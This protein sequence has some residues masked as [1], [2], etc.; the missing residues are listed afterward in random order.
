MTCCPIEI[1][2]S[3]SSCFASEWTNGT[4]GADTR[5]MGPG[6]VFDHLEGFLTSS[7]DDPMRGE[8]DEFAIDVL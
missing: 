4:G 2:V 7:G 3:C 6:T 1:A 8:M 5:L